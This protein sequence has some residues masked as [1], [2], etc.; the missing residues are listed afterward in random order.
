MT[1]R[2][3]VAFA[4]VRPFSARGAAIIGMGVLAFEASVAWA[5]T[6]PAPIGPQ[7]APATAPRTVERLPPASR[8]AP[9]QQPAMTPAAEAPSST[10][11]ALDGTPGPAPAAPPAP[12]AATPT[13]DAPPAPEHDDGESLWPQT[14]TADG[15]TY[16]LYAPQLESL[17]ATRASA[18]C[19]FS[20]VAAAGLP[21]SD[22]AVP[23]ASS[24]DAPTTV[25]SPAGIAYGVLFFTADV[26][27][28]G[29]A[30]L[31]ELSDLQ[32]TRASFADGRNADAAATELETMLFGVHFT[33][34]RADVMHAMRVAR[35]R[36][37][38]RGPVLSTAAPTIQVVDRPAVLLLLDGPPVLRAVGDTGIGIAQNTASL[39]AF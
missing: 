8:P 4:A 16:T 22:A 33:V 15:S 24:A 35:A 31:I 7:V 20:V 34:N 17:T 13:A 6:R 18:R 2:P 36:G 25:P 28:D 12:A 26:D 29:P 38:E 5:T 21:A 9:T 3:T 39:L 14:A 23:A 10:S 27:H 1:G 30:G 19:A 37:A 11:S 32:V